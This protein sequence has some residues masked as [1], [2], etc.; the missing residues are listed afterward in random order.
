M[1]PQ[2]RE[3]GSVKRYILRQVLQNAR[4]GA[5]GSRYSSGDLAF[6]ENNDNV[7]IL[8]AVC[9]ACD[10]QAMIMVVVEQQPA[11]EKQQPPL[12]ADDVLDLHEMLRNHTGDIRSLLA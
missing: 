12:T 4:C 7:W 3:E 1:N 11:E 5:C 8:M 9:P 10:T 6:L 2:R